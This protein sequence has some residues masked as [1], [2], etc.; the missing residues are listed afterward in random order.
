MY[1]AI[2]NSSGMKVV[3]GDISTSIGAL[4]LWRKRLGETDE[5][6]IEKYVSGLYQSYGFLEELLGPDYTDEQVED[7]AREELGL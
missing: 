1:D 5:W 2:E 3:P 6:M 4:H 7:I